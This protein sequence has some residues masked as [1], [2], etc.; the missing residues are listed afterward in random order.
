MKKWMPLLGLMVLLMMPALACAI[1]NIG[2]NQEPT[3]APLPTPMGDTLILTIPL[4][5]IGL[6]P[7]DTVPGS[8]LRYVGQNAGSYDVTIGGLSASKRS[9]DSF[10]W[11]GVVAPGV[12]GNYN[13]RLTT[14]LL[15]K[16]V[17]AGPVTLNIFNPTPA[18]APPAAAS[19]HYTNIVVQYLIPA[20]RTIPG[21]TLVYESIVEPGGPENVPQRMARLSGGNGYPYFAFGDSIA[22]TGQL[23]NNV[24]ISY[25]LRVAGLGDDGLRVAGSAELW[26]D[27]K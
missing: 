10:A 11:N 25:S 18:A 1:P 7:G 14:T 19:L 15:G 2:G 24:S 6:N 23:R 26:V 20:G 13:L 3:P 17:A 12:V 16:L 27:N 22:W 8:E 4:Y 5:R 21:T 9:G